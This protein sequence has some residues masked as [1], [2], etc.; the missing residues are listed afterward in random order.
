M[1]DNSQEAL[2]LITPPDRSHPC[3]VLSII[4]HQITALERQN[5]RGTSGDR[6]GL[7]GQDITEPDEQ[8]DHLPSSYCEILLNDEMIY[9]TRTKQYSSTPFFEAGTEKFVRDWTKTMVRIVV[10]D[11]KLREHVPILGVVSLPLADVLKA[12]SQ[13]TQFRSLENG[14]GFGRVRVSLMFRAFKVD[15]IP[16]A[17]KGWETATVEVKSSVVVRVGDEGLRHGLGGESLTMSTTEAS[18]KLS[19]RDAKVEGE[20]V[21][22]WEMEEGVR[23]PVYNRF[24]SNV[25]FDVGGH[26]LLSKH[27]KA[28]AIIWSVS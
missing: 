17:L 6:E 9:K 1:A 14:V 25:V 2:A 15:H 10:R 19:K 12:S 3:G 7:A 21:V 22:R 23:L 28:F 16:R 13:V 5:L 26:S 24:Q 4:V 11:A 20:G 27:P 18:A 8:G